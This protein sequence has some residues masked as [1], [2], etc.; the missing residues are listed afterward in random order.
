M[1]SIVVL[2]SVNLDIVAKADRLP[3][4]GE[5]VTDAELGRYPGG[6]GANQALAAQRLGAEVSLV[7]RVG[8]DS[9]AEE[10]LALLREGG[11][12][13]G[14]VSAVEDAATGV[15]LIAVA[16]SG[17]N[18]IV[19]RADLSTRNP[20]RSCRSRSRKFQGLFL[21]QSRAGQAHRCHCLAARRPDRC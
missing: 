13:L 5:T 4:A 18:Q 21:R 8:T 3:V 14:N 16:A 15:A 2:G 10:A 6:K 17:E 1:P 7:A 20:D 9:A 12:D 19:V 11:V